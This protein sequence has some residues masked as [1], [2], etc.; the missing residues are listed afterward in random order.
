MCKK[1]RPRWLRRSRIATKMIAAKLSDKV[2]PSFPAQAG[3]QAPPEQSTREFHVT[4]SPACA[5]SDD[6]EKECHK[7][8]RSS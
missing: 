8:V 1:K 6:F 3:N 4:G 5:G 7:K 2:R